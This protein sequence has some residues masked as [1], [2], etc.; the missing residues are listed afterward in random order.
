[1]PDH[2]AFASDNT[3]AICPL[4]WD[5][6]AAANL[7]GCAS[8]Y[9]EDRYTAE[10]CKLIR[11]V[12][13]TDC[14]VFFV[15][16]GTAANALSL[17]AICQGFNAVVCHEKAHIMTDECG[18]PELFTGG[19]KL[20]GVPGPLAKVT[21]DAIRE[22]V[23]QRRDL[24]FPKPKC[25]SL[26]QATEF[27]TVYSI[28][29]IA[30]LTE[31]ARSENLK[32]HLDG[33]RFANA[34]ATL[35]CTPAEVTW[36][37]GIDVMSFGLTKLGAGV[38]EAVVFFDKSLA[39]DFDYRVKRAGQ[40]ASKMRFVTASW[41]TLLRDQA[42]LKIAAEVNSRAQQLRTGI[43]VIPDVEILFPIEANAV[44]AKFPTTVNEAMQ[45]RDWHYY[46]L[47][48]VGDSRLMCS[49]ATTAEDVEAFC[50]DLRECS[51]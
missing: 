17:S 26:T 3:A 5:A 21:P 22:R 25:L 31:C 36:K 44:F 23:S 35:G 18:A 7:D 4:A 19:S 51:I 1:M 47:A 42:W 38:G 14:E 40:L 28:D 41:T 8:S 30:A 15:F 34:L 2:Y 45:A 49:W 13:E 48:G 37:A 50:T 6:I 12:F 20:L 32:V 33:A 24:H 46:E 16:N 29:E 39:V 9:G 43:E 27:G 10:A 11:E